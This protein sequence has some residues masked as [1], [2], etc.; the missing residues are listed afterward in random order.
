[1]TSGKVSCL[2]DSATTHIV[3]RE[4]IYFT[5]FVPKNAPLT[6]LSGPSNLIE[7]YGQARIML[8]NGTILTIAEA[9]YSPRSGRT[10]LSFKDIRDNNYH[11]ETHVENEV[12]FLCVTSYEYGQKRILEKMERNPSGLYTTTIHPIECHYV[13][14][15]TTGTAHEITLW[16]DRLGHPGRIAMRRILKTSHGHP[17]TR[18]LGSIHEITCQTCSMGKLITKPSYDKIRSN[19]PIFLQRIQG[20]ICG[21]IQPLCG[22]FRY[23]MVLVDTSTRW[24]HVCL[25]STRNAAFSKLLAQVIKLR[26]HHPDYPIKSIR[27]DNAGEFTSKTFDD[28]CMSVGVEVE[29]PVPHVHTQNGL[30]EAFIKRLQMIARSLV[31]RTKLPIAAWGHAILHAAKLVRLRPVATQPFSALQLVTGCEPDISH[32]RVFGCAVYVPISP[33]LRTKMGP[34]RRMRIYVGYD[35]PS[36]IR[37]LEPLTGD[38]FT[39]RFT[40]CHFYETVFPSLGGDKNVNVPNEQ[41]ELSWTTPTLSHLD[42]RTA[43]SEAE[44]Q[45][46][47][48]LQSIAQSMPDAFTDLARVTRS[49]I[50]AANTPAKM[51]VPN[52]RRTTLLKARGANSGDPRTLAASQSSAPTQKR[53]RP[54]GSKDSHPR[55]RKTTAQGPEEP[56]VNPTIAYSF[57]PTHEEILDYG[58]VLEETNPPPENR[59]ISVYYDSLDDV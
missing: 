55:K 53:G 14:G 2:A 23:F 48:D 8:S 38:L 41:R 44:V 22:P 12:E 19:P 5:N 40:D 27:L 58:S 15:P 36:I 11:A 31:I 57:Y 1:M 37:Y 33:P 51:D 21:P 29:H 4:H 9:L 49:H 7:G 50:P 3:L 25:L 13:A 47:L 17:L 16:H 54:L 28:Y 30:A 45:R 35:S 43:Q 52:V 42:P 20:D 6:T 32:L 24:S 10:L 18:S 46:I 26:A 34:Q 59:E 56:T 39:A